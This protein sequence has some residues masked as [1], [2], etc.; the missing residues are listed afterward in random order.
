MNGALDEGR[1]SPWNPPTETISRP[2]A[3]F[4]YANAFYWVW[5]LSSPLELLGEYMFRRWTRLRPIM[6]IGLLLTALCMAGVVPAAAATAT[7]SISGKLTA[8]AGMSLTNMFIHVYTADQQQHVGLTT[9]GADNTYKIPDLPAGSYKV[10]FSASQSGGIEQWYKNAT[11][12]GAATVVTVANGQNVTGINDTLVKG[13]TISGKLTA[14]AGVNLLNTSV[15]VYT[16]GQQSSVGYG[17]ANA[18]GTYKVSG[19]AAGAYKLQFTGS[20][21]GVLDQWYKNA[22][23][24]ATAATVTITT[25]QDLTG[26]NDTL[27]KGATISG[28]LTAPAGVSSFQTTVTA[29]TADRQ[30]SVRMGWVDSVGA[31]KLSGLPAG[32]Y[33]LQFSGFQTGVLYSWYK[34][35]QS[36]DAATVVTVAG[37]QA[38]TGINDTLIKSSSISGKLTAPAGTDL[39]QVNVNVYPTT[40]PGYYVASGS[41]GVDGAYTVPGLWAGSYKVQ[42]SASQSGAVDQWYKNT[43]TFDAATAVTV[44]SGQNATGI[45]DTLAKGA[46]ISGK[47]T[48]PAGVD[49]AQTQ[50][51]VYAADRQ[52][53]VGAASVGADGTYKVVG[54]P[55]GSYKLL[56]VN[57]R[58]LSGA[59]DQWYKNAKSFDVATVVTLNSGQDVTGLND[60]LVKSSSISGKFTAPVGVNLAQTSVSVYTADSQNYVGYSYLNVDGTYKVPNL[61]AG[62]YKMIFVGNQ[63]GAPD[64][65]YKN[66]KSYETATVVTLKS[67]QDL[68]GINDTL[69]KGAT[70]SGKFTAPA[71]SSFANSRV[72]VYTADKQQ[73]SQ[74]G[75]VGSDGTYKVVGLPAGSYK[76]QFVTNSPDTADQWYK[77]AKSF[78]TATVV[79]VASGQNA[80]GINDTLVKGATIS[81]SITPVS[82]GEWY[83]VAVMDQSGVVV[84][85]GYTDSSTGA[86]SITGLAA[87][88]YKV[89]FNRASGSSLAEAQYYQNKSESLGVGAAKPLTVAVGQTLSN[90]SATLATGGSITGTLV[91]K[92]GKP[93]ADTNVT[94][95]TKDRSLIA[96]STQ[97]DS[98]GKFTISGLT[99]GKY[100]LVANST[101]Y[102]PQAS[103]GKLYSGNATTEAAA[104]L[105]STTVGKATALGVMSYAA[106]AAPKAL[107]AAPVPTIS[108]S[109]VSGLKLTATAGVWSPAP[110]ALAYQWKR[111]GVAIAGATASTYTLTSADV[112]KTITVTVTGSKAGYATTSKTSV[113]TA[114][115]TAPKALTA[116]PVPT[117][118]GSAVSGLKLTATTGVW[119]PAPV[120]LAYQW[121]RA[122]V[123]IAGAT[124]ATYTLTST[125]VG[126]TI[127]VTVTG[128]KAGYATTSKT[129]VATAA[130]TAPKA[131]T[132]APVPTISGSA[133]SGLK[134]TATT[135]VWSPAPVAL[136]Y[137]WKRAGVAIAGA[138]AATYTLTSTDVGKAITVTVTG[139]KAGY[140]TASKT[141]V[142]TKAVAAK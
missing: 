125:D 6:V 52:Q 77:N 47:L 119:S 80:T 138:T 55:A 141:S 19:L 140:V 33:K 87:G 103:L 139:S 109:A 20:A 81:G 37:G 21:S 58:Q 131:L 101:G 113:A 2:V 94:A 91:D 25:G 49:L 79:T 82:A 96:R 114:A 124:A 64:Q 10:H 39:S 99:T 66:A 12:F 53:A 72:S 111:A 56:F 61:P 27:V 51:D 68:T 36:F 62:S 121:K 29:Y 11:S 3:S 122:G 115:V 108:G 42:F 93:I 76:L 110:V 104:T 116:A 5:R 75:W 22:Q 60:T 118:S 73:P 107:T 65:W 78:D 30:S 57:Y 15:T 35:A 69:V 142:A 18:D 14:P 54:L 105:V 136:A 48:A 26:I 40:G 100:V 74:I 41:V 7:G 134:L 28:K 38:I 137:Q 126:K 1:F 13:A 127:T 23:S 97:T 95:Y 92:A 83:P 89:A 120:A 85:S 128:S 133:V 135:G 46:T 50:V 31:Y 24:F 32:S 88:S 129:S 63:S 86:Y 43:K 4:R 59:R 9:L 16:A 17:Y 130:V 132:A 117:I 71:G 67:A 45:N 123:A 44:A 34:N 102:G 98:A 8:P 84:K 112:G 90:I 106:V 70:I